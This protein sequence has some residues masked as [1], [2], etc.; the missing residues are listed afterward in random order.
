MDNKLFGSSPEV[1]NWHELIVQNILL[2]VFTE[3]CGDSNGNFAGKI[4]AKFT[5]IF[6]FGDF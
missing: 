4:I 2:L 1:A 6:I 3:I 5:R